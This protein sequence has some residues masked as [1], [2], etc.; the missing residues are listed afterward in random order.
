MSSSNGIKAEDGAYIKPEIEAD[1]FEDTGECQMPR[2]EDDQQAWL[3]RLPKWLW[4][5]WA[6]MA[7]DEE[8]E[9]GKV[10]VYNQPNPDGSQK[11]QMKLHDLP[12]HKDVP[13]LYDLTSSRGQYNNTVVFSERDQPGFKAWNPNRVRKD[14]RN[15]NYKV[16]KNKP[17]TSSIPKQTALAG[18]I[19]AEMAVTAVENEEYR[20]LTDRR[21][22]EMFQP[23]R[24]TRFESGADATV[25]S[26]TQANNA[27]SSFIKATQ[28]KKPV[29]KQQEKAV[30][31]SQEE[32]FDLLTDCFKQYRYWSL[33]ALKQRLHQPE[34]FIKQNVEKIATL[35][36]S[37]KF[38]MNYRLNPEYERTVNIDPA[39][40]KEEVADEVEDD[41]EDDDDEDDEDG[42]EDVKMEDS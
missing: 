20:R 10:R 9:I 5:A 34:A 29:K 36:R 12:K 11:I 31:V 21:F 39:N 32:L 4:T 13:K 25:H 16:N 27:F 18:F 33:K 30:R 1:E 22:M 2:S 17:Y 6:D 40:V 3:C 26:N 42:Y 23:K 14:T 24:T 15:L 7:D 19:K 37:G 41:D 8:I 38:A 35:M 28:A